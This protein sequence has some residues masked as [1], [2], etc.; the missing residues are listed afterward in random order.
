MKKFLRVLRALCLVTVLGVSCLTL[1]SCDEEDSAHTITFYSSMGDKL[2]ETL[3]VAKKDF[4]K[5]F[6]G[7]QIK[8][9]NPGNG[10]DGTR[11]A[12]IG[13]LQA[14]SQPDLAYCY[15]D[16]VAQY[17]ETG[18]VT[19]IAKFI[20]STETL[21]ANVL[22]GE[23]WVSKTFDNEIIGYTEDEIADFVEG[24]YNEGFA[25]N[26]ANYDKYGYAATDMLTVP[27]QKS[28]EI[29]YYNA[30]ALHELKVEVP[31]TWDELWDV[32]RLAKKKWPKCIP[33]GYDSESNW[34][35]TMCEQNGWDYTSAQEPHYLFDNDNTEAWLTQLREYYKEG[36]FTTS[37]IYGGY[38]S[39]LFKNGYQTGSVFSIGSSGGA[40][41]QN[42]GKKFKYGVAPLPGS[43]VNAETGEVNAAAISQGPSLVMFKTAA[44]NAD[45]KE[46]MTWEFVKILLDP[47][48]QAKFAGK[49]G[50]MP[51]RKSSYETDF[52]VDLFENNPDD[53]IVR[54][55]LCAKD[56]V[57]SQ[58]T[59]PAFKGSSTARTQVGTVIIYV[60]M[61]QKTADVALRDAAKKCGVK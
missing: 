24:Y 40:S 6:P 12:I 58:F 54:T 52:Y 9:V 33:L 59:S 42:P 11:S 8:V 3:E 48:F 41:Y 55:V 15:P 35:I 30:D 49:T 47:V 5:K 13:D 27:F 32:C 61:G 56:T 44:E 51:A 14:N 53:I 60:A 16:H 34:F 1:T 19:N 31:T 20:N 4:A 38:S 21:T 22:Q 43:V 23:E 17:L 50:Y 10:Y 57:E 45:E 39:N 7:W 26:Y 37:E 36:L 28:T 2:L 46:L 25:T 29:L 18:K